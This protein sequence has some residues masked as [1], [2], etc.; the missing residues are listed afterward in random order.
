MG[1]L[2]KLTSLFE[3]PGHRE[4]ARRTA[5]DDKRSATS[6]EEEIDQRETRRLGGMS[7]EDQAWEQAALQRNRE[8]PGRVMS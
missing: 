1:I 6:P 2:Q 5:I 4:Q 7:E 3:S 8:A